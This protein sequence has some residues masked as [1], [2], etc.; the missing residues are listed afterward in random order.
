MEQPDPWTQHAGGT[1]AMPQPLEPAASG[2]A[3]EVPPP[4]PPPQVGAWPVHGRPAC[5]IVSL[6]CSLPAVP[7]PDV[8]VVV[9]VA[10]GLPAA[11][12]IERTAV[13][14]QWAP[15]AARLVTTV[16]V[17]LEYQVN[18]ELVMQQVRS[19]MVAEGG[20]RQAHVCRTLRL[21]MKPLRPD[22]QGIPAT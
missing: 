14:L 1:A 16:P 10:P 12:H 21:T 3:E 5:L 18:F 20:Q 15:V 7:N 17:E 19:C 8:Q 2:A 11:V 6:L 9:D 22:W 13:S 4:P